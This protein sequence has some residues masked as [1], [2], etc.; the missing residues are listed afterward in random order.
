ME[1]VREVPADGLAR[2]APDE[3]LHAPIPA[4]NAFVAV[5]DHEAIAQ[6][7]DDAV[8][9]LPKRSSSWALTLS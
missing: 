3:R 6:R 7:L 2:G 1:E 5:H 9:E 4:Q 8:A